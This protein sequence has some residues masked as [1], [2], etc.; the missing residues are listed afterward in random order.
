[1]M[2][3]VP[4]QLGL[5]SCF[6]QYSVVLS[7]EDG[8]DILQLLKDEIDGMMGN[9]ELFYVP[10][11]VYVSTGTIGS[12]H[13]EFLILF[14]YAG[15]PFILSSSFSIDGAELKDA[16]IT[17]DGG[18]L[19]SRLYAENNRQVFSLGFTQVGDNALEYAR[20]YLM[21]NPPIPSPDI[22]S[23]ITEEHL[24]NAKL[25]ERKGVISKDGGTRLEIFSLD[26]DESRMIR[27]HKDFGDDPNSERGIPAGMMEVI[28]YGGIPSIIS[29]GNICT[30]DGSIFEVWVPNVPKLTRVARSIFEAGLIPIDSLT[31]DTDGVEECYATFHKKLCEM[32]DEVIQKELEVESDEEIPPAIP[33]DEE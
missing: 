6:A 10:V 12:I 1:M 29:I 32:E 9:P 17:N 31:L 8:D 23:N 15:I 33:E 14:L 13:S 20:D 4:C 28:A 7:D 11:P 22:D 18:R 21:H 24:V 26:T 3:S 25:N 16:M 5:S 27:A 2:V 30:T 19:V